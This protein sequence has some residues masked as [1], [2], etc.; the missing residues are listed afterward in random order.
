MR[1]GQFFY[2]PIRSY[3]PGLSLISEN[4]VRMIL[5]RFGEGLYWVFTRGGLLAIG[6]IIVFIG[7]ISGRSEGND[8]GFLAGCEA[9]LRP[10]AEM[11]RMADEMGLK[12]RRIE[13][14]SGPGK[15][16]TA[17]QQAQIYAICY[18]PNASLQPTLLAHYGCP[19]EESSK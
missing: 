12:I 15:P 10:A 11:C 17:E 16:L 2:A 13:T 8:D 19:P 6:A 14:K 5:R 7:Y 18:P 3:V 1:I 4:R 9:A